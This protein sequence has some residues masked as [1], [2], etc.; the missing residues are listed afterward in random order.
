MS[1][2]V[3]TRSQCF[4]SLKVLFPQLQLLELW[5]IIFF[6][7]LIL[8]MLLHCHLLMTMSFWFIIL[9]TLSIFFL[10]VFTIFFFSRVL[11]SH[12]LFV[13]MKLLNLET[14]FPLYGN[15]YLFYNI[16]ISFTLFLFCALWNSCQSNVGHSELIIALAVSV[17]TW[18]ERK[19]SAGRQP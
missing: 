12:N 18:E 13:R 6:F 2:K 11:K 14:Q 15:F 5:A 4:D 9:Y 8:K 19:A 7:S 3:H 16:L 17:E 1:W 10:E